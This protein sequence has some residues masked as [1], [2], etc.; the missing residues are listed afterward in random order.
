MVFS[1]GMG[2]VNTMGIAVSGDLNL[3]PVKVWAGYLLEMPFKPL[4]HHSLIAPGD[5]ST[6]QTSSIDSYPEVSCL[7]FAVRRSLLYAKC[8]KGW[9]GT[10]RGPKFL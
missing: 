8:H 5:L 7:H 2:T 4:A 1:P 6:V 9:Q 10:H 3:N